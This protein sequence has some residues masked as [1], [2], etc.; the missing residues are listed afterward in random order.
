MKRTLVS[1]AAFALIGAAA[2]SSS[3]PTV[4]PGVVPV[5]SGEEDGRV[6]ALPPDT[7]PPPEEDGAVRADTRRGAGD[8][9]LGSDALASGIDAAPASIVKVT[10]LSPV[11]GQGIDGGGA[12]P[13]VISVRSR[14]A[15]SVRIEVQSRGGDPT[16]DA[17]ALVSANLVDEKS[18]K[19]AGANL[20]QTQYQVIPESGSAVYFYGDTPLDLAKVS[21]GVYELQ[22]SAITAGGVVAGASVSVLVDAGPTI[23]FLQPADGVFVKGSLVVTAV[24]TDTR[25]GVTKVEFS[26][27]Q[28]QIVPSLVASNGAQYTVNLDFGSFNP[29]L[30]GPQIVTVTATN[31]NGVVSLAS[32]KFTV[33]SQGPTILQTKPVMGELIGKLITIEAQVADP[34]GVME[35]SVIAVVA[36]GD[37]HFEVKLDKG[38]GDLYQRLFDTTQLPVYS[39]FP[40]ISFRAQDVLGNQ[41][42]VGYL[43][44]LDNTPPVM[45]LDPPATYRIFKEDGT[46]SWPFDPVGPDA[47][48]DGSVVTQ[49][50]DI[51]ARIEDRGNKPLTGTADYVPI[52]GVAANSVKVLILDDT[53]LPLVVD[54]SDPP[55]GICDDINPELVPS[56]APQSSKDAQLIDM[57]S[58]G[59]GAGRGDF[60]HQP[61]VACSGYEDSWSA[62]C[63]STYNPQKNAALTYLINYSTGLP[64]IWTV[65]PVNADHMQCAG[66]QFDASNN[67][68]D[69]WACLAVEASDTLGNK[70]VSRPIRICVAAQPGS[71]ACTAATAGGAELASVTLPSS[72]TGSVVVTTKAA[73][74]GAGGAPVA[75]GDTLVFSNV[76]PVAIAVVGGDHTVEPLG[77]TG[78]Q[79]ILTDLT[80]AGFELWVDNLDGLFPIRRGTVGAII[81][82]GAEVQVVTDA[83]TALE[84]GFTGGVILLGKGSAKQADSE[85]RWVATN[86]QP[87][88]FVL[89]GSTVTFTGFVNASATLPNC[90]G[91][92]SKSVGG[93]PAKVDGTTP[94]KPWQLFP[95][96]ESLVVP[97]A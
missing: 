30:D 7:R 20:N 91:T 77:S 15:P 33:D 27:G 96:Y 44:S 59:G 87:G 68:H 22:V 46:C 2:C 57:V 70:Q 80:M 13:S 65:P 41:S 18:V 35:G 43:V 74:L 11:A 83:A 25:S 39:I 40:S 3:N 60:T 24:V 32:R 9:P 79:F 85:Q 21:G 97:G 36:H 37:V 50:F 52:G 62:Y 71:T 8:V 93:Q 82:D 67:L 28:T 45:D 95:A 14:F 6:A 55:D 34:A 64:S 94:C 26:V 76:S 63:D 4:P 19:V 88:G 31:G 86:I 38:K 17:I 10:I 89:K 48:D 1:C 92:V 84:A 29:P 53:S 69:G 47:V 51:R 42:S 90:T 81:R 61:G 75:K 56:V 5:D 73:V 66:R 54:T 23:I 58:M 49:L 12:G 72:P 16:A 78:T